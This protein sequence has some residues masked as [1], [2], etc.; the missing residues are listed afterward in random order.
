MYCLLSTC[1]YESL[2][3]NFVVRLMFGRVDILK[4]P[5]LKGET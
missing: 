2:S 3:T 5:F 4:T 1:E